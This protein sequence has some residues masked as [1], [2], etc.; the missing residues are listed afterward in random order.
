VDGDAGDL[1][2]LLATARAEIVALRDDP[3]LGAPHPI[4]QQD[5]KR[6]DALRGHVLDLFEAVEHRMAQAPSDTA[7]DAAKHAYARSLR[8]SIHMLRAAYAALPWLVATRAPSL[9]LG[10]LYMTEE[11]ARVLIGTGVDLVAVPNPEYMYATTSR[12]FSAVVDGTPGFAPMTSHRPIVLNYP[13]SD[14]GRLLLHPV[15]AH[16]LD[17][18][19]VD[20]HR[21]VP[22]IEDQLDAD[23]AFVSALERTVQRS[24]RISPGEASEAQIS[25]AM[26]A[27]LRSWIEELL[28]DHLAIEVAGP[29]FIWAFAMFVMPLSYGEPSLEHPP[30]TLR[31]RLALDFLAQR[32]WLPYMEGIAPG[33]MSW[34]SGIAGESNGPLPLEFSFLR[35]QVL[36]H[37]S[38]F[39]NA[40]TVLSGDNSLAR[41]ALE[42]DAHEAAELLERMILPVGL[43]EPLDGRAIL[44][45][46]WCQAFRE[47]GDSPAGMV[48]A[49]GDRR[50]QDLVGKA[51]ELS[52]V[53]TAWESMP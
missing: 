28:C 24:T 18:A 17:H 4:N 48:R 40:A 13:L 22:S 14:S 46:G 32:G 5:G 30:N 16:E 49:L 43:N 20:E 44:L 10:S 11:Y 12:P 26:R 7:S 41:S 34:L 50:L 38:S 37:A 15:F 33:V 35:D 39:Q 23:P 1:E 47:H 27:L 19:G 31:M 29:A 25:G 6:G 42:A 53:A 9:N 36:A 2:L 45:G 51:I 3:R 21:L 8:Q 52:A